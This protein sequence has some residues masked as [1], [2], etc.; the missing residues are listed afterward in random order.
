[1]YDGGSVGFF[2]RCRGSGPSRHTRS[3]CGPTRQ[4]AGN[5]RHGQCHGL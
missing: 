1:L 5:W 3:N 4:W 2:F